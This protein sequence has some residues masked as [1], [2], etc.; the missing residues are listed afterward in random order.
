M[1]KLSVDHLHFFV[2][3]LDEAISFYEDLGFEFVRRM[4]HGGR[5][6]AQL[7]TDS[8]FT[9]DLNE[10]KASDNPGYSHLALCV[11][12]IE[13]AYARLKERGYWI[14]GPVFNKETN[15]RIIT[16]RDPNGLLVQ[17]VEE[18]KHSI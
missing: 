16:L 7:K 4:E 2:T 17:L 13:E 8:G 12:D 14:D 3:D 11:E 6:A 1:K 18:D 9:V 15:R 5:K 10:T